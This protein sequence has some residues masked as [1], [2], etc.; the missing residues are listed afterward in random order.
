MR[1]VLLITVVSLGLVASAYAAEWGLK[2]GSPKLQSAGPLA[3]GPDGILFVGDTKAAALVAIATGDSKGGAIGKL[4]IDGLHEK[5]ANAL[6]AKKAVV[7]D[8]AVN[9]S[10]GSVYFSVSS[11]TGPAIVKCDSSGM[12]SKLSL[13]NVMFAKAELPDAPKDE[14][15]KRGRRSRN[16][17]DDSITDIAYSEG[18]VL[19]SGQPGRSVER[20][21][22]FIPV[23]RRRH[24][25]QSR[26]LPR[27][28]RSL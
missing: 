27:R 13:E 19:I 15:V 8:L 21:R 4:K 9:R 20:A 26:N 1:N 23:R 14:V 18:K 22:D 28:P 16:A 3:I 24:D 10:A 11:E 7:H 25:R 2:K 6:G 12:V 17:R 5:I